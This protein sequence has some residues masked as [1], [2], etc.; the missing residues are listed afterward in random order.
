M[1]L[2][3]SVLGEEVIC[4]EMGVGDGV[5]DEEGQTPALHAGALGSVA[6]DEGVGRDG[7][8]L[9]CWGEFCF[10]DGCNEDGVAMEERG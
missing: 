7:A 2:Y 5:M 6:S 3:G 9:G 4:G 8:G 10:L 1:V